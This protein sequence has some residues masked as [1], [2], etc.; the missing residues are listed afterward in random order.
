MFRGALVLKVLAVSVA[1]ALIVAACG[2]GDEDETLVLS[3][4]G[5]EP[6]TNAYH[7]EGWA[8]IGGSPV[9]TGK[10][11]VN[12]S[13]ALVDLD[14]RIIEDGEFETGVDLS[15]ANAI[16]LT[17]EPAGDTDAI[18][19]STHYL[20]GSVSAG[21]ATLS[22]GH[23]AALGDSF[24]ASLGKYILA[25]PTDSDGSN[26]TSGIWFVE[27]SG[28]LTA[29]LQLPQLP[30][31]WVY[32]GWAVINGTP[33]TTGRFTDVAA[34]DQSTPYSGPKGGP[35]F[36]GEDFLRNAPSG[37]TFPTDLRG[38]TAVIS[39]EPSPDDSPAP[40]KLKP[41]VGPIPQDAGDHV[42]YQLGNKASAFP[43]GTARIG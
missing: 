5:I 12:A 13:G 11:N 29:G 20:A 10:F 36:P 42:T 43:S 39:I 14:G 7:Y 3:F 40:F 21:S 15:E 6:L 27:L 32:E 18:P 16:V 19:T 24:T 4:T 8:I 34:A 41:L 23:A 17:I 26:E 1:T 22:V 25:T 30:A 31:G 37:L 2:G 33:V 35:P 28:G 9:S 38:A